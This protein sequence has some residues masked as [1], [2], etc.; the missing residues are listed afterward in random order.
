LQ[1]LRRRNQGTARGWL[2]WRRLIVCLALSRT[3]AHPSESAP[4]PGIC[5]ASSPIA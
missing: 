3:R 2:G 1:H 5:M 4:V